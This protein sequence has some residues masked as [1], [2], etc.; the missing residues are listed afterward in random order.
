MAFVVL[1]AGNMHCA[2]PLSQPALGSGG[3]ER[4][5]NSFPHPGV[6]S[7]VG[8]S[9]PSLEP[10]LPCRVQPQVSFCKAF[11]TFSFGPS[12]QSPPPPLFFSLPQLQGHGR[13]RCSGHAFPS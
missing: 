13:A 7:P 6:C 3:G 10:L 2:S 1:C 11:G 12:S 9:P 8:P 4:D 5:S